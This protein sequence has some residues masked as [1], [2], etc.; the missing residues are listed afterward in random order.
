MHAARINISGQKSY[1]HHD[2][3][4][5]NQKQNVSAFPQYY[6]YKKTVFI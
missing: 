3:L 2:D 6:S 4:V 1:F 5:Q